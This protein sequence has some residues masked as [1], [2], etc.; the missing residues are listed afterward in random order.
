MEFQKTK[1]LV[2]LGPASRSKSVIR[3]MAE[4]GAD[5]FRLNF[6]HSTHSEHAEIIDNIRSVS[7]KLGRHIGILQDLGGPKI[8][9]GEMEGDEPVLLK[10]GGFIT[11]TS[12]N[13]KGSSK[14]ISTNY[15]GLVGA[16]RVGEHIR[17][18]DGIVDLIV[19][20]KGKS[21][22]YCEVVSGGELSARKGINLPHTKLKLPSMTRKDLFDLEFGISRGVDYIALSFVRKA[23][24]VELLKKIL[25]RKK[26]D[27]PV[28]A[29]IEKPDALKNLDSIINASDGIMVA[30]G[31][32]ATETNIE[33]IP[34]HQKEI[35]KKCNKAGMLVITATQML[36]SMVTNALPTRAESTD[37][38]N[39]IFDGTDVVMLS[40]ETS[41]GRY[42]VKAVQTMNNIIIEAENSEFMGDGSVAGLQSGKEPVSN[43]VTHAAC[44]AA[45]EVSARAILVFSISGLTAKKVAGYHPN[46]PII[47]FSPSPDTLRRMSLV[48][49]V[50]AVELGFFSS[51]EKMIDRGLRKIRELKLVRKGDL[52]VLISGGSSHYISANMMKIHT[53]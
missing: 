37:V 52:V 11:I 6:S 28:I 13:I 30:R 46:T 5:A 45:E 24:D 8:R 53:V 17:I 39:A 3:A 38:A 10:R 23:S 4:A 41:V 2:T 33:S 15:R 51:T 16:V 19:R 14:I 18:N 48:R 50:K 43:T 26:K 40:E 22:V 20:K 27:I 44:F 31:D 9:V 25:M 36:E 32:L 35:I 12:S 7:K 49:G 47:A 1:I 34:I 42:P 29:K 21:S